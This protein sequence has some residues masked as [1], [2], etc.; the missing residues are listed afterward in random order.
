MERALIIRQPHINNVL[1][2]KKL[3][4]MRSKPTN[5]RGKI[6]LIEQGTGLIVGEVELVGCKKQ[7]GKSLKSRR[8]ISLHCCDPDFLISHNY[9]YAWEIV[10]AR[11]Y[12]TSIKY[13]HC[14]S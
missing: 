6:G 4:E 2:N 7:S 14:S 13:T 12:N 1:Q 5:L 10:N 3:W 11:K 8:S 9:F